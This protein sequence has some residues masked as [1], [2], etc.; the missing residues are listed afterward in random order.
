MANNRPQRPTEAE[1]PTPR[2][3]ALLLTINVL[4]ALLWP[5]FFPIFGNFWEYG[6]G[7][8]VGHLILMIYRRDYLHHNVRV[9][10]FLAHVI[11]EILVSNIE[12]AWLVLQPRP[13]L[14]PGIVA[15]PLDIT[16]DLEITVLASVITLTPGTLSVELG[17]DTTGRKVLYV[18]NLVVEDP[19]KFRRSIKQGFE[20]LIW[21]ISR[22]EEAI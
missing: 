3:M 5:A 20:R 9:T 22:G 19:E 16:T 2:G 6:I 12:L 18:H 21:Q 7:F 10:I 15:I 1:G 4:I 11:W 13:R 17:Q 8:V 14:D